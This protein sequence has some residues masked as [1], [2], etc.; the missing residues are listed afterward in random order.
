MAV[1]AAYEIWAQ[2]E[3][4]EALAAAH[5]LVHLRK[6]T[7]VEA[8]AVGRRLRDFIVQVPIEIN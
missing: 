1:A 3:G 7:G 6:F 2:R 8:K 4:I 5:A